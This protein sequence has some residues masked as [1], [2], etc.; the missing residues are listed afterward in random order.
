MIDF[1]NMTDLEKLSAY[2]DNEL[3]VSDRAELEQR[4]SQDTQLQQ[5][6]A[7]LESTNVMA[8][9]YFSELDKTPLPANLE[10]MIR[11]AEP[12]QKSATVVDIFRSKKNKLIT[13]RWGF[14]SAAS[15]LFALGIWM[16]MPATDSNIN[17]RLLAV[18]NA[19]PSGSVTMINPELKIEVL[20]SYQNSQGMVCRSLIEHTPTSS[21]PTLACLDQGEWKLETSDLG[22]H[23]QTASS[24]QGHNSPSLTANKQEIMTPEQEQL[25]L[26]NRSY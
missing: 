5:A 22:E 8:N 12:E 10:A 25:W 13:Q 19:E 7:K 26:K 3:S 2:L 14:A 9:E 16:L 24:S 20:A 23:Y 6:L 15:V 17:A 18:L 1:N 21:N 11:N 4:L